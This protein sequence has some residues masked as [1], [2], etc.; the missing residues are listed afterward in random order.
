VITA[1]ELIVWINTGDTA[2]RIADFGGLVDAG[3]LDLTIDRDRIVAVTMTP[4]APRLAV[5]PATIS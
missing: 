1:S 2:E 5:M 3:F 4:L